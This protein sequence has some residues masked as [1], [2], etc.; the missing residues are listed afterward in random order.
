MSKPVVIFGN[1]DFARTAEVYLTA[2]SPHE[3]AA[4]TV[5]SQYLQATELRGKPVVPFETLTE[6]HP[7]D[8]FAMLVAVGFSKVNRVRAELYQACKDRGYE[9]ISYVNS[10]ALQWGEITVGENCFILENNVLQPF[11]RIGNNVVIWSG[12]HVG[13]DV[14]IGDHCFIASHA[15]ISGRVTV[16]E[17]SF[18]G[19]NATIRDGV[20]IGPE[21]VIGAG[22]LILSDTEPRGVYRANPTERSKVTS[23]RLRGF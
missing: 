16:G 11:V 19:V 4:F 13:H 10:K 17:Y 8:R 7:P 21:C 20:T 3:V 6:T 15:V 23:D 1:G 9:C 12:N 5:H 22:A 2:D 18:I 14:Q